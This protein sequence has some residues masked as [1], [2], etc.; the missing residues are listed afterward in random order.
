MNKPKTVEEW[1]ALAAQRRTKLSAP[2]IGASKPKQD[3]RS[4]SASHANSLPL[5][6]VQRPKKGKFKIKSY[7]MTLLWKKRG[8]H[9]Y[10]D[11]ICQCCG[12]SFSEGWRYVADNTR[13]F[14]C[15][16]CK[17]DIKPQFTQILYTPMK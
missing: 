11:F 3:Q 12:N 13:V 8:T 5:H 4:A 17:A 1:N 10:E 14:L 6:V 2:K 16:N 15:N 7:F 9:V